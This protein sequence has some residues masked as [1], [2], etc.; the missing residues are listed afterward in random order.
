MRCSDDDEQVEEISVT[1][2]ELRLTNT[3]HDME[4][5]HD[6]WS[7]VINAARWKHITLRGRSTAHY[8][9]FQS[10]SYQIWQLATSSSLMKV[11]A[12]GNKKLLAYTN[13]HKYLIMRTV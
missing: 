5:Q 4:G 12:A 10:M 1:W 9:C 3:I 13:E 7:S 2:R 6:G 11:R 8:F